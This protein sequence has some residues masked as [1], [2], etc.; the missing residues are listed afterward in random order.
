[1]GLPGEK[2]PHELT[3][4]CSLLANGLGCTKNSH[5]LFHCFYY[6][7]THADTHRPIV[8]HCVSLFCLWLPGLQQLSGECWEQ[9]VKCCDGLL[10]MTC[11]SETGELRRRNRPVEIERGRETEREG[12]TVTNICIRL[13]YLF[14]FFKMDKCICSN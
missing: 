7:H 9:Q 11:E 5:L 8:I 10:S 3:H 4:T 13:K 2:D 12:E 1:M 6:T 14:S